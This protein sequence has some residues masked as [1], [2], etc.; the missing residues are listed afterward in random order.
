MERFKHGIRN[1]LL[2]PPSRRFR[3]DED[4]GV[5]EV[6]GELIAFLRLASGKANKGVRIAG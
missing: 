2:P 6:E 3:P 4:D 5:V 1:L